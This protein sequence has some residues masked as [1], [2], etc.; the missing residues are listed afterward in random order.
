LQR[1][2]IIGRPGSGKSTLARNIGARL[3]LPIVHLDQHY[4]GPR[5]ALPEPG[6]WAGT[7]KR[8]ADEERWVMDGNYS[9]T[10][11]PRLNRADA[12]LFLDLPRPRAMIAVIGRLIRHY[13]RVREDAAAGCPERFD[14][15]FLRFCWNWRRERPLAFLADFRG[16]IIHLRSRKAIRRFLETLPEG[17]AA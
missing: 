14:P 12:V 7:V 10:L 15:A 16:T 9:A 6:A 13:G 11:E 3:G 2:V 1:L 8:L 4:F 17:K 5:W